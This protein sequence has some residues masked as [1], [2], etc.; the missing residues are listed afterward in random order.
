MRSPFLVD[1]T[2]LRHGAAARR[3]H[4][5]VGVDWGVTLSRLDPEVPLDAELVLRPLPGGILVTGDVAFRVRHTCA[6]C[7]A[8]FEEERRIEVAALYE[9]DAV[10][11]EGYPLEGDVLDLEPMV[12]DEVLLASPLLPRCDAPHPRVVA[13]P[14]T[15]LNTTPPDVGDS[16]FAALREL[17]TSGE[18]EARFP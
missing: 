12:R 6:A 10:E 17:L 5:V 1:I 4:L 13:G 18:E 2:D 8:T 11:G 7:L 9:P 3:E 15:D 16:P 14:G